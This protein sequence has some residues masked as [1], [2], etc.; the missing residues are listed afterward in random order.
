[1][2]TETVETIYRAITDQYIAEINEAVEA[3]KKLDTAEK[4][5]ATDSAK[6]TNTLKQAAEQRKKLLTDELANL[7]RLQ[8]QAKT[9]FSVPE[10]KKFNNDILESKNRISVL[11]GETDSLGKVT[12]GLKAQFAALGAGV[13]AAFSVQAIIQ[14]SKQSIDAFLEA[15][16]AA[17]ALRFAI[18]DIGNEG[19]DAFQKLIEQS[20]KVQDVTIFSDESIQRAQAAL[21]T[22]GLTSTQIEQLIPKL[23]DFATVTNQSI[24]SAAQSIGQGLQGM[25]REFKRFGI[26]VSSNNTEIENFRI[27]L[28][29]LTKQEGAAEE[30]AKTLGGQ[31]LQLENRSNDLQ[32]EVG[33]RL[34]PAWVGLK[35]AVFEATI[36]LLNYGRTTE[37]VFKTAE[38]TGQDLVAGTTERLKSL[39]NSNNLVIRSLEILINK[40]QEEFNA[41]EL[42]RLLRLNI[43]S[44]T[45]AENNE[46]LR[47][48]SLIGGQIDGLKS[49]LSVLQETG[50]ENARLV[51]SNLLRI[52]SIDELNTLLE[53]NKRINDIISQSNVKLIEKELEARKKL[54]ED[55]SKLRDKALQEEKALADQIQKL[56]AGLATTE[57]QKILLQTEFDQASAQKAIQ[58]KRTFDQIIIDSEKKRTE[59]QIL[60][61][62]DAFKKIVSSNVKREF[63]QDEANLEKFIADQT[64]IIE[65]SAISQGEKEKQL[66]DLKQ[67]ELE[68]RIQ[69]LK[70]YGKDASKAELELSK[71]LIDLS[72]KTAEEQSKALD[73]RRENL[74]SGVGEASIG[75][76]NQIKDELQT[77][78]ALKISAAK[79]D[80]DTIKSINDQLVKDLSDIDR[81]IADNFINTLN[82][83]A[84]VAV[85]VFSSIA[86]IQN[87]NSQARIDVLEKEQERQFEL[88]DAEQQKLQEQR[89]KNLISE[90]T[91][92]NKSAELKQLRVKTEKDINAKITEEKRK[93]ATLDRALKVFEITIQTALNIVKVFPN[94]FLQALA[95]ALGAL[96]IAAVLSAPLPTFKKGTKRKSDTGMAIVGEEGEEAV[97]LPQGSKVIPHRQTKEHENVFDAIYDNR[98]EKFVNQNYIAPALLK[99]KAEFEK[100]KQQNFAQNVANS[101]MLQNNNSGIDEYAMMR[102]MNKGI[103]L[104]NAEQ[105]GAAMAKY[106]LQNSDPR[107]I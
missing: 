59:L 36:S 76:L 41:L 85:Q 77:I 33:R 5:V 80:A 8:A 107:R 96:Q 86:E 79:G 100:Q 67:T 16:K 28:E 51:N 40:K 89:N 17:Q 21:A 70:D 72:K 46:R 24:D 20:K 62:Q 92:E 74:L 10:I 14:F 11:R 42:D 104:K 68:I 94:I 27:I 84:D 103:S 3:N 43:Q 60:I 37:D 9:A 34:T 58:D 7:K 88:L 54:S 63:E 87:N 4:Q 105:I 69:N 102:V 30:A 98:F 1:M 83:I 6:N 101:F 50:K 55:A 91:F 78:S 19:E 25:G 99:Q 31:L 39:N 12:N 90:K 53:E 2:A 15:E 61:N 81:Q 47:Q 95:G 73:V 23:A 71:F 48:L 106:L 75:D 97:L 38:Q 57:E 29:G 22:F 52:K 66:T 56:R 44:L 93:Q 82:Q 13:L 65:E 64:K 49:Q 45:V 35:N 18:V 32:E 26:D